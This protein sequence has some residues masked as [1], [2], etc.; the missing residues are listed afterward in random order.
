[1]RSAAAPGHPPPRTRKLG[2]C[3]IFSPHPRGRGLAADQRPVASAFFGRGRSLAQFLSVSPPFI[4]ELEEERA[5][6]WVIGLF[7]G[8]NAFLRVLVVETS[9]RHGTVP[10]QRGRRPESLSANTLPVCRRMLQ[11]GSVLRNDFHPFWTTV[12]WRRPRQRRCWHARAGRP[13]FH[14]SPARGEHA[15][16]ASIAPPPNGVWPGGDA[17][18][19]PVGQQQATIVP[20]V[21]LRL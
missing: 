15:V 2:C 19:R 9:E 1:M 8:A 14:P 7:G 10:F 11:C 5:A 6:A 13:P 21:P 12:G 3:W 17:M 20:A 16:P 4:G 18:A